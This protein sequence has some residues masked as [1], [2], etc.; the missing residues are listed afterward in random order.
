MQAGR[1]RISAGLPDETVKKEAFQW[2]RRGTHVLNASSVW[3]AGSYLFLVILFT[4]EWINPS[5]QKNLLISEIKATSHALT[6][7][8]SS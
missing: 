1:S 6:V 8:G 7:C 3:S 4:Q 5:L 2:G